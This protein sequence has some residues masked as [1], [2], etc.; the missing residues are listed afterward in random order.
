[1]RENLLS[2]VVPAF[3]EEK[4]ISIAATALST[5][6][7]NANIP[8]EIVFVDDGSRDNTWAEICN[9]AEQKTYVRGV[10]FSKNFGKEAAI[11]AGLSE[12]SGACCVVIDCDLQHPPEKIVD[13]YRLWE[14]GYEV[15]EGVKKDRGKESFAHTLGAKCFNKLLSHATGVDMSKASDFK[16]LDRRAVDV[17]L[18]MREKNTFFRGLSAWIGFRTKEVEFCVAG[19]TEGTTK[20][21]RMGLVRYALRNIASFSVFP[22]HLISASGVL[23]LVMSVILSA[24]ALYQKATHVALDGFTTVIVVLLFIGS[25]IMISLGCIGYYIAK[26]YEEIKGRPRYIVSTRCGKSPEDL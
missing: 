7:K 19:R 26:I 14:Q 16:L 21:S 10:S 22:L 3:N 5:I 23:V 4:N 20:W 2:V 24:I 17:L 11:F 6:L 1:M 25:M 12:A 8:F 15:I 9:E 18:T 13:M